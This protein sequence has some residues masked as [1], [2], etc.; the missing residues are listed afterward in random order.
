MNAQDKRLRNIY[1][2]TSDALEQTIVFGRGGARLSSRELLRM[3]NEG[4]NTQRNTMRNLDGEKRNTIAGALSD[5]TIERLNRIVND[6][7]LEE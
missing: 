3:V 2:A 5:K 1:V 7:R 4:K 6:V